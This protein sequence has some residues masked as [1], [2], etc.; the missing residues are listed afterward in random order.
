MKGIKGKNFIGLLTILLLATAHL[1]QGQQPTRIPRIGYL[2][3]VSPA[4]E[5]ARRE[6]FSRGLRELG[7]VEG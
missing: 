7:Y 2:S 5:S 1:A 3:G 6:A 4:A